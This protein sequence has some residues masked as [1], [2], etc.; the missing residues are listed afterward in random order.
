MWCAWLL[1]L[2]YPAVRELGDGV[3]V[4]CI[5]QGPAAAFCRAIVRNRH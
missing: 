2:L 3:R 1:L 5:G 4:S